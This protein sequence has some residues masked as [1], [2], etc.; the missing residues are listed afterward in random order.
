MEL[1]IFVHRG[2]PMLIG[3]AWA[4]PSAADPPEQSFCAYDVLVDDTLQSIADRYGMH[5]LTLFLLNNNS[6]SHPDTITAGTRIAVGRPY[7]VRDG[8]SLYS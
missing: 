1:F 4:R 5:W 7:L 8:D 2:Q 6:L 3:H